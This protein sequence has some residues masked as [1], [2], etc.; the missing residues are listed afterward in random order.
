MIWI[1][2]PARSPGLVPGTASALMLIS[3]LSR[4]TTSWSCPLGKVS[5]V[6]R[7]L[8]PAMLFLMRL[9][10]SITSWILHHGHPPLWLRT[11]NRMAKPCWSA[12]IQLFSST[13]PSNSTRSAFFSSKRFLT[14]HFR[15]SGEP[16]CVD[17]SNVQRV[18]S[19]K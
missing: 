19:K 4:M 14:R 7:N 9:F 15:P 10:D 3:R 5:S 1:S 18:G 11:E 12:W 17:V 13:L 6:A 8:M 16:C 2:R